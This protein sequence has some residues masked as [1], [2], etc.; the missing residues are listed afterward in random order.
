[1][2]KIMEPFPNDIVK[3]SCI[4]DASL[5]FYRQEE[6][7]ERKEAQEACPHSGLL[8]QLEHYDSS[9]FW[10]CGSPVKF[11][12]YEKPVLQLFH[13]WLSKYRWQEAI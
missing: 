7:L 4:L 5:T 3:T 9:S 1:M 10:T 11:E 8:L 6:T 12:C 2:E 13:H